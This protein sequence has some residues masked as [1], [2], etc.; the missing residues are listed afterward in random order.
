[1][2]SHQ[3]NPT[4]YPGM[5][6]EANEPVFNALWEAKAFAIVNQLAADKHC[7]WSEWTQFLVDEISAT[8]RVASG[9]RA[10]YEQWVIACEKLLAQK[11]IIDSQAINRRIDELIAEQEAEHQH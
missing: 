1:M 10:Y 4:P 7:T 8:E 2:L 11:G 5:L 6:N 9:S 3:D